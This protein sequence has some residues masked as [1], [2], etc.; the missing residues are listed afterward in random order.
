M[1]MNQE[2]TKQKLAQ[3]LKAILNS[4]EYVAIPELLGYENR[5]GSV[6]LFLIGVKVD[7]NIHKEEN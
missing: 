4:P 1:N 2:N 7:G 6:F 3:N 5:Y